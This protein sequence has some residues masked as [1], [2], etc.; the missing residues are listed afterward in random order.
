MILAILAHKRGRRH[1]LQRL[2]TLLRARMSVQSRHYL[3]S[4]ALCDPADSPWHTL[5]ASRDRGSFISVVS[6]D[7]DT[8]DYLLGFS[9]NITWL[10]QVLGKGDVHRNSSIKH[11]VLGCL[12]H[13]YSAAVEH[14]SLCE[15]LGFPQPLLS[16]HVCSSSSSA[17]SVEGNSR[18]ENSISR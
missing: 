4:D 18:G 12:L 11:G 13:Y 3:V 15:W 16:C 5:Y 2:L 14:K 8:F 9:V 7:P 10:S 1:S 6:L 17:T